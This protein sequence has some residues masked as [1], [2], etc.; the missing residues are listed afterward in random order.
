MA[1]IVTKATLALKKTPLVKQ[2]M[3][4]RRSLTVNVNHTQFIICIEAEHFVLKKKKKHTYMHACF[5]YRVASLRRGSLRDRNALMLEG[6]EA[7]L[8]INFYTVHTV[9]RWEPVGGGRG[10]E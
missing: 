3:M 1:E 7:F 8:H 5:C 10:K 4:G 2:S 9:E 6:E